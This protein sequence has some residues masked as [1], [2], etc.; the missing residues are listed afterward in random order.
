VVGYDGLHQLFVLLQTQQA[1]AQQSLN[2][3]LLHRQRII[4]GQCRHG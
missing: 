3:T 4:G 2:L 1:A